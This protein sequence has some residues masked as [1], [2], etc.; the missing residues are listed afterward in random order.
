MAKKERSSPRFLQVDGDVDDNQPITTKEKKPS[1]VRFIQVD[2]PTS[3]PQELPTEDQPYMDRQSIEL[4]LLKGGINV[5]GVSLK[6]LKDVAKNTSNHEVQ[7]ILLQHPSADVRAALARNTKISARLLK[8]LAQDANGYVKMA[9]ESH[10][11]YHEI[12]NYE[13]L[14]SVSEGQHSI[15]W[16]TDLELIEDMYK[17]NYNGRKNKY[18]FK[19]WPAG[20]RETLARFTTDST[21]QM[22]LCREPYNVRIALANNV[23]P[24]SP[25]LYRL[26]N[27][28]SKA[29]LRALINRP[30]LDKDIRRLAENKLN[31][32]D[33]QKSHKTSLITRP[34]YISSETAKSVE[35]PQKESEQII[36]W[37]LFWVILITAGI[38]LLA[39]LVS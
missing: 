1:G 34:N 27:D 10:K 30:N 32:L 6:E 9:A 29:V 3:V 8:V 28:N 12:A 5:N 7:F 13:L 24:S 39:G 17:A 31:E 23:M 36:G 22:A 19:G 4:A 37:P 25:L 11:R 20:W 2:A 18:E 33:I 38:I 35:N 16:A 21:V 15:N 26:A 14:D